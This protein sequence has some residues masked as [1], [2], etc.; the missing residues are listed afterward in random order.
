MLNEVVGWLKNHFPDGLIHDVAKKQEVDIITPE[1][2]AS[3][4]GLMQRG[5]KVVAPNPPPLTPE[6]TPLP[7]PAEVVSPALML[8]PEPNCA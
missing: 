1:F 2:R 4:V 6:P 5:S 3:L 7:P 8:A